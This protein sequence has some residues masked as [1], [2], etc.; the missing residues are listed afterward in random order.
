MRWES[1]TELAHHGILGMKWGVRRYQKKDGTLTEAGKKRYSEDDVALSDART[2]LREAKKARTKAAS[3]AH[4]VV[5]T[6]ADLQALR[7]ADKKYNAAKFDYEKAKLKSGTNKE[8]A[9]IKEKGITFE[10]KSK[11]RL[12]LE[13]QY[14]QTGM[15]KEEAEAAANRR[16]R[17]EKIVAT[18]AA[19][20]VAACVAYFGVSKYKNQ[21]DQVIKAGE[22]LQRIEMR[23]TN[24]KLNEVF[25]AAKGK[26]DSTRYL[27]L[28][29]STRQQQTGEA[30]L[31][32]LKATSDIKVASKDKAVKVFSD[33]YKNDESFR[34][35]V[36]EGGVNIGKHFTGQN[37]V[38]AT[39][40]SGR[41]L[42]KM[43]ENFNSALI[44]IR[45]SGSGADKK[46]YGKLKE[47]GYGAIQDVNDMKFSGYNAKNPLIVFDNKGSIFA[48]SASKITEDLSKNGRNE[49]LKAVGEKFVEDTLKKGGVAGAG[50]LV[51][52]TAKMT[53]TPANSSAVKSY[54]SAHPG[55]KLSDAEILKMLYK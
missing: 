44:D 34:K 5:S 47:M 32:K 55:T 17:A 36:T 24:G 19:V 15:S 53:L 48:E 26:H 46:F 4:S 27:N 52:K 54:R 35:A 20:T 45:N 49:L 33:L 6:N 37:A 10:N 31:M 21:I 51:G 39:K 25:Y 13:E 23:D 9:R 14:L 29:G 3:K 22:N 41:N 40:L 50:A 42:K 18:S 30:W 43:Y 7:E 2:K 12:K 1:Q 11:H 8:L 38:D 28:L 16:I